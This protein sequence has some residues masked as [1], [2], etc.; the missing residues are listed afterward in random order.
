MLLYFAPTALSRIF[1]GEDY[2]GLSPFYKALTKGC[3]YPGSLECP[4]SQTQA[5]L[6]FVSHIVS[7]GLDLWVRAPPFTC[8]ALTVNHFKPS[9]ALEE[10][11]IP[12][13]EVKQSKVI[14]GNWA[15]L[16]SK[17]R[18]MSLLGYGMYRVL[19]PVWPSQ[20][21]DTS[22]RITNQHIRFLWNPSWLTHLLCVVFSVVW[23]LES[24]N[25]V[26]FH[27]VFLF[28][29]VDSQELKVEA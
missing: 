5:Q 3:H 24:L 13:G 28:Q 25:K 19:R 1:Y 9:L 12:L 7:L 10:A 6:I 18:F 16:Q 17:P 2:Q 29:V 22:A 8:V 26:S 14:V 4:G 21:S 15:P 27:L 23:L 20:T 11:L